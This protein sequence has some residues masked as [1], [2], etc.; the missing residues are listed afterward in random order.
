MN[1]DRQLKQILTFGEGNTFFSLVNVDGKRWLMP[2]R[3]MRTA[4][5]LYQPSGPKG[6][7]LKR[8]LPWVYWNPLVLRVL[9][10]EKLKLKLADELRVLLEYIF[11]EREL[12][13]SV[14]CGTP[15]VHQKITI[16][17]S[18]GKQIL[19]Y[20]KL[21]DNEDIYRVF[22]HEQMILSFIHDRGVSNVPQCLYCGALD[23]EMFVF[24]QTTVKT[25]HSK[26]VHE[27]T[28][29]HRNFLNQ[30]VAR[31]RQEVVFEQTD[32]YRDLELL[33]NQLH[34]IDEA[35]C[36]WKII[37][38]VRNH[39]K[40]KIVTFSAF[41]ADFTPWNMFEEKGHLF[42]FD[43]EYA[44]L[45]Y[46]PQLDYFHFQI[47]TAV[48][49]GHIGISEIYERLRAEREVLDQI[50]TDSVFS[51]KCYL[52]A[53]M[54]LYVNREKDK[55]GEETQQRVSFWVKLLELLAS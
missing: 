19:G 23:G 26:V 7:L 21:T 47:Q 4:M 51:L 12:E 39:Y 52:L 43:W 41:Q 53:V 50:Y 42:V 25:E 46:P 36:V 29:M 31:T 17:V 15:S 9:H 45:T 16:Q 44:R 3:N 5:N 24:V 32:F 27:W 30:L 14:F 35:S 38:E 28:E 13:F 33:E 37:D 6:K 20:V 49:E 1:I 55:L 22:V 40:G 2:A 8:G 11:G 10:A 34:R 48:F 54:S 18:C